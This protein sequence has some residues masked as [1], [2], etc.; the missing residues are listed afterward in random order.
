[1]DIQKLITLKSE[2]LAPATVREIH[3]VM[4]QALNQAVIERLIPDNPAQNIVLPRIEYN[5][6]EPLTNEEMER[7][8]NASKDH[9]LFHALMLL[10]GTGI[11]RGELLVCTGKMSILKKIRLSSKE[12]MLKLRLEIL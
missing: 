7:L 3:L 6:I 11:R 12:T 8:I 9:R 4:N 10:M 5:E 2:S 1:M